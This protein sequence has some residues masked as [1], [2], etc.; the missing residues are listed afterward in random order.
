MQ[1]KWPPWYDHLILMFQKEVADRIVAKINTKEFGRLSVLANWRLDV[2][3]H[4]DI[5][6]NC[7]IPKPKVKSTLLSFVPK[8]NNNFL[9]K[10]PKNLEIVTRVLFSNRRKMINKS[11]KKLFKK[12]ELEFKNLS[13][14]LTKRPGE[15]SKEMYYKIAIQYEKLFG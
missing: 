14:D 10:N 15:L 9:L 12:K 8:K 5:S 11:F 6:P 13:I 2:K 1:E 4:F 3:K 7:F